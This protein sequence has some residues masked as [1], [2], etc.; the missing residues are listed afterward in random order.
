MFVFVAVVVL[1]FISKIHP[2]FHFFIVS[3]KVRS[4]IPILPMKILRIMEESFVQNC[5]ELDL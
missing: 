1:H 5:S 3:L 4:I 2:T